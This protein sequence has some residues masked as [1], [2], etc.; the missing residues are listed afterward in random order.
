MEIDI[1]QPL[2]AYQHELKDK[3]RQLTEEYFDNLVKQ[4]GVSP[5]EN[6]EI[7]DK[8]NQT[9]K[10]LG[11]S[12]KHVRKNKSLRAFMI[13][14][15]VALFMAAIISVVAFMDNEEGLFFLAILLPI[16]FVAIA[17]GLILLICKVINK[18]IK[19]GKEQSAKL[20]AEANKLESQAWQQMAPLNRKYDWNTPD[21]LIYET[22]PQIQLDKYFDENKY[23]YFTKHMGLL[24]ESRDDVSAY[25]ARSGNSD[26]NP[27]LLMRYIYHQM[28]DYVYTGTRTVSW[29]E[30]ETD[31]Q[32]H[33]H[34]VTR[35][36][37]LI[38]HVTKPKPDYFFR[39]YLY[40]GS[41][42]A[43]D[44]HFSRTP[45]VPRDASDK[46]IKSLVKNG[47][48]QLEK[49]TR[50]AI[51]KGETYNK[52]ANS[53]FEVL[54]GADNRDDEVQFRMMFTP[55]AQQNMV[56]LLKSHKPYGDDFTF[57]KRGRVNIIYSRHGASLNIDANPAQ[58]VNF[59][60]AK[61][62]ET[63]V[64][65]NVNYFKSLY[66]DFAPLFSVPIYTQERPEQVFGECTD[67]ANIG[68]C[69]MEAVANFF[70]PKL[71]SHPE[72]V[73][74]TI[75]KVKHVAATDNGCV[76]EITGY[77]YKGIPH[78]D[79]VPVMCRNGHTYEVEVPWIEYSPLT[80]VTNVEMS[81]VSL[82]REDYLRSENAGSDNEV[83]FGGIIARLMPETDKK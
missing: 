54:F 43:P 74:D 21:K 23:A 4:S 6:A 30:T 2:D 64:N 69:E 29:T 80:Q 62:K 24:V 78:V 10:Q 31:A 81:A 45:V 75:V 77:S 59:D 26:G 28:I 60:L 27:F 48:K 49:K 17:V 9:L 11:D 82:T 39:T 40:Y 47:E 32:G 38:A 35:S 1:L 71:I 22:V 42:A 50:E 70:D 16:L 53:E 73:T 57:E 65:Y 58:F 20:R 52:L 36:E 7:I 67:H 55:L 41:S 68:E 56:K 76:A 79:F 12:D 63:F 34:T 19:L 46:A 44:L 37:T 3:H 5:E 14:C 13:V 61:A 51:K 83:F 25:C 15:I 8:R 72:T 18:R 66:F 33:T